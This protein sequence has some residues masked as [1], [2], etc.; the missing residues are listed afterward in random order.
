MDTAYGFSMTTTST[1]KAPKP[2]KHFCSCDKG[3]TSRS[4]MLNHG[5]ACAIERARSAA[6]IDAL[7]NGTD[8]HLAAAVAVQSA[9]RRVF[10]ANQHARFHGNR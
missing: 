2:L 3:F 8:P 10:I 6:W 5:H 7:E 4:G 1:A 9:K